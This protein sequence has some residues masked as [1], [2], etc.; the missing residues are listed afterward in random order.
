MPLNIRQAFPEDLEAIQRLLLKTW[1]ATYDATLGRDKVDAITA[2]WHSPERLSRDL[3]EQ[4]C[5]LVAERNGTI[6]GTA[7]AMKG[8]D[9]NLMLSRLYVVPE[10][11]GERIGKRLLAATLDAFPAAASVTL[12][13]ERGNLRGIEFYKQAGF[14]V[15]GSGSDC[16][17]CGSNVAHVIMR[18]ELGAIRS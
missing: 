10:A 18:K 9:G 8:P 11:Q 17:G 12:E 4:A 5:F 7:S 13:V 15:I 1:H 3:D 16:G 6:V 14:E 2:S